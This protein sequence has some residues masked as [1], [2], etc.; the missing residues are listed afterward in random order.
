MILDEAHLARTEEGQFINYM[1]LEHFNSVHFV[2]ATPVMN[3]SKDLGNLLE[4]TWKCSGLG[5]VF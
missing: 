2:S 4:L 3:S 5:R 1:R